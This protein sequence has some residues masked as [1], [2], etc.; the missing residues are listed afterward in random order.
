[1]TRANVEIEWGNIELPGV[2]DEKLFN[3]NWNKVAAIQEMVKKR[4]NGPW[5]EKN[6]KFLTELSENPKWKKKHDNAMSKLSKDL[7]WL[8]NQKKAG[9][10]RS[11]DPKW[12]ENHKKAI[13]ATKKMIQ[14]PYGIFESRVDAVRYMSDLGIINA[15]RKVDA[16]LKSKPDE[17][18]YLDK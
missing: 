14:T 13:N 12:Q 3:T 11:K 16:W 10:N 5:K 1:M 7:T 18:Y 6:L 2:S 17:Y 15:S 4:S 8:E 9:A